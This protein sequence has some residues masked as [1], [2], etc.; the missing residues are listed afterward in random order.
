MA[1]LVSAFVAKRGF[2]CVET[3]DL[4]PLCWG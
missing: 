1:C 2:I 4:G 3:Q